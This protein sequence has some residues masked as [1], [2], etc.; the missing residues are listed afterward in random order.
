VQHPLELIGEHRLFL[1]GSPSPS[2]CATIHTTHSSG[3]ESMWFPHRMCRRR[4]HTLSLNRNGEG[5]LLSEKR[6]FLVRLTDLVRQAISPRDQQHSEGAP[7]GEGA[8]A[9]E[10]RDSQGYPNPL[11]ARCGTTKQLQRARI[12]RCGRGARGPALHT[13]YTARKSKERPGRGL[14]QRVSSCGLLLAV[15]WACVFP[16]LLPAP[17][18]AIACTGAAPATVS[19]EKESVQA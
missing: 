8:R 5:H 15:V 18:A 4:S 17:K 3:E 14:P 10:V 11:W 1:G 13:S 9:R 7:R 16:V 6:L 12:G 19:W 2:H